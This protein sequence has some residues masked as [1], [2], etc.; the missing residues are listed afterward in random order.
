MAYV[1]LAFGLLTAAAGV[2]AIVAPETFGMFLRQ[3][4]T[5]G[6]LYLSAGNRVLFGIALLLSAGGSRLPDVL[7]PLGVVFL[8]A[9]LALP[10]LGYEFFRSA[11]DI[12]LSMGPW[13]ARIWGIVALGFG[14]FIVYAVAPRSLAA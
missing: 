13:I 4:Q 10:F 6:G 11:V 1:S 9:G 12:F 2:L 5:P 14:L 8:G 7:T 3:A